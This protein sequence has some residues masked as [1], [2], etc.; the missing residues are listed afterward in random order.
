MAMYQ[1]TSFLHL[2]AIFPFSV[3][4]MTQQSPL[5]ALDSLPREILVQVLEYAP[6]VRSLWETALTCRTLYAIITDSTLQLPSRVITRRIDAQ[7]LDLAFTAADVGSRNGWLLSWLPNKRRVT[8]ADIDQ[9]LNTKPPPSAWSIRLL[10]AMD[11]MHD[12]VNE[13][14]QSLTT[15][16][17]LADKLK[18]TP[19]SRSESCRFQNAFYRAQI[20]CAMQQVQPI[21]YYWQRHLARNFVMRYNAMESEQVACVWDMLREEVRKGE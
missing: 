20:F 15:T 17:P 5:G 13:I 4:D 8:R 14:I 6:D 12:A 3:I 16:Q 10:L 18:H 1:S 7:V 19:M 21:R 9:G 11:E 2:P